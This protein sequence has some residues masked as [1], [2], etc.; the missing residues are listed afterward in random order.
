MRQKVQSFRISVRLSEANKARVAL[1]CEARRV[2]ADTVS[3]SWYQPESSLSLRQTWSGELV[4]A[5]HV[6]GPA[7]V[8]RAN[9]LQGRVCEAQLS[10]EEKL[11]EGHLNEKEKGK[12]HSLSKGED[13]ESLL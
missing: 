3:R 9:W 13:R 11:S 10:R 8:G 12:D 2:G 7:P 1:D 4:P 5:A 6:W